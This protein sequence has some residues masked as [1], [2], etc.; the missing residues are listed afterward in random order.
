MS[1]VLAEKAKIY[2]NTGTYA[3]PTWDEIVN[4]KDLSLNLDKDEVEI[5]TRASNGFKEFVD[6]L[7]DASVEFQ[8]VW[9]TADPDFTALQTAFFA[10]TSIEFLVLDGLRTTSGTQ[11][12]RATCMVKN[13]SRSETLGEAIMVDITIRPTKNA[14]A[15]PAWFTTP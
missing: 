9:N 7:I 15:A 8:M 6:G 4:V 2:R 10:K 13:F 3:S 14:N 11:G 1:Y 12:L 5:T